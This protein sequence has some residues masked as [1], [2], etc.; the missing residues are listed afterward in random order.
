MQVL[1]PHQFWMSNLH[2]HGTWRFPD[3]KVGARAIYNDRK[4]PN[5]DIPNMSSSFQCKNLDHSHKTEQHVE[6]RAITT[7]N[8]DTSIARFGST[9]QITRCA[10]AWKRFILFWQSAMYQENMNFCVVLSSWFRWIATNSKLIKQALT[11]GV[12]YFLKQTPPWL[13][14]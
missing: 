9:V 11:L 10:S 14:S 7:P 2:N 13:S 3:S 12:V 4:V 8:P 1:A 5:I 6:F